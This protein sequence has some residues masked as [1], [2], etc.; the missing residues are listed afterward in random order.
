MTRPVLPAALAAATLLA[1]LVFSLA[2]GLDLDAA[3]LFYAGDGR[4]VGDAGLGTVVRK[5]FYWIPTASLLLMLGLYAARRFG[6]S[7]FWAPTGR[8]VL[9]LLL[10]FAIGPGLLVNTMLK[11]HS[12]R[13]RPYQTTAF[14]GDEP[15]R[16]FYSFDGAC[17]RN[18][19][20]VSGEGAT[21]AWTV[22]PA[23]LL[24]PPWRGPAVAASLVFAACSGT[25]RMAFG[26]HYFSDA[27]FAVLLSWIVLWIGWVLILPRRTTVPVGRNAATD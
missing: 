2:P 6:R 25:L 22:G 10:T 8:G 13:P 16:P 21:S 3:A 19:S 26:G 7:P 11:E 5:I 27:V 17:R 23:L 9:F 15:F 20:F 12:H 4:F 18:C 1:A 24:P 14:G